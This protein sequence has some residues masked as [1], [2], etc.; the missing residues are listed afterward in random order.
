VVPRFE[1][2]PGFRYDTDRV[3]LADVTA[4]PYDVIDADERA[5]LLARHPYNAV[6][7]DCPVDDGGRD[8]YEAAAERLASWRS[9]GVLVDDPAPSLYLYRM[10]FTD[11]AGRPRHTTGVIGALGLQHPGEGDV[12]PH[13]HTTPKARSDR[14]QL[15]RATRA[16]LSAVWAL[17]LAPGLSKLLDPT[18]AEP[19]DGWHDDDGVHHQLWVITDAETI[20]A[21]TEAIESEPV[22]IADGHHRFETCLT[23]RDERTAAGA[24][25]GP[26]DLTMAF[27][28]ELVDDELTVRPIHRLIAGLPE[29]FD[30]LAAF[31]PWFDSAVNQ[32][33]ADL[34]LATPGAATALRLRDRTLLDESGGLWTRLLD[35]VLVELP[36]HELTYQHGADNLVRALDEGRAQ[37]GVLLPPVSVSQIAATARAGGRMPPK[38]T[39]FWPKPRTGLVFRSLEPDGAA[40]R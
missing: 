4:P 8:C 18:A 40:T 6:A 10:S 34:L 11:E 13:E 28:V 22:V 3:P 12:L 14:L 2:F 35:H 7:V 9:E 31:E 16:N 30:V 32:V 33:D 21:V 17:S 5:A 29:G 26:H 23:Y 25:P 1:P 20:A 19:V 27:V 39:F 24:P 36:A 38:T 15:L 37:A